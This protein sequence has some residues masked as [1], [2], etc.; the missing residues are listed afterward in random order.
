MYY[1][2]NNVTTTDKYD[3]AKFI[4][5]SDEGIFDCLNSYFLYTIPR[6]PVGGYFNV[7]TAEENR[8]YMVSY[9]IY[10]DTQYW[11]IVMWY[12][13]LLKPQ[14]IKSGMI[15]KYPSLSVINQLFTQTSLL[16]KAK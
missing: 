14:D 3:L 12:N 11:W 8:P 10:S 13:T 4:E 9:K 7:S 6:L 2:N 5:F 15:L 16:Q 1:I